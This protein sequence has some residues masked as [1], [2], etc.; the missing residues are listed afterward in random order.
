MKLFFSAEVIAFVCGI[1]GYFIRPKSFLNLFIPFLAVTLIYEY[2]S[3]SGWFTEGDDNLRAFNYMATFEFVFYLSFFLIAL[4]G[5]RAQNWLVGTL[6]TFLLFEV[7]NIGIHGDKDYMGTYTMLVGSL[8]LIGWACYTLFNLINQEVPFSITSHPIFWI[9]SGLIFFYLAQFGFMLAFTII[10]T[11]PAPG[12]VKLFQIITNVSN[13]GLYCCFAIGLLCS[14]S[15]L[16][17]L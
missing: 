12:Y 6:V 5:N 9:C 8:F 2:G 13:V 1:V 11:E 16:K 4:K 14:R 3:F 7:W 15:Q 10:I 17:R